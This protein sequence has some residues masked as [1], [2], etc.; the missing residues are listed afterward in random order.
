MSDVPLSAAPNAAKSTPTPRA[1]NGIAVRPKQQRHGVRGLPLSAAALP[2][3]PTSAP[4]K[5]AGLSYGKYMLLKMQADKKAR[6]C[7]NTDESKG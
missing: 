7:A 6:R 3:T 5:K 2:C 1:W 4:P